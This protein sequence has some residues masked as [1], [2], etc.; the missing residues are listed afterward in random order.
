[1]GETRLRVHVDGAVIHRTLLTSPAGPTPTRV[2]QAWQANTPPRKHP[3]PA[4]PAAAVPI[5]THLDGASDPGGDTDGDP[6]S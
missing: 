1:M 5:A 2:L 3:A 6:R 4:N